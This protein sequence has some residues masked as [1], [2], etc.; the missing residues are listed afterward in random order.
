MAEEK[1]IVGQITCGERKGLWVQ[2]D[3]E[4]KGVV[5]TI[6]CRTDRV[7][8]CRELLLSPIERRREGDCGYN[9][10]QK[11][12]WLTVE[13]YCWVQWNAEQKG[14]VGTVGCGGDTGCRYNRLQKR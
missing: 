5:G 10:M 14:I 4:E 13:S 9:R 2:W 12:G 3:A 6:G 1:G 7:V 11:R 8:G